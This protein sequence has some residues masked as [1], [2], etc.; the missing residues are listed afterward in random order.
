MKETLR[1]KMKETLRNKLEILLSQYQFEKGQAQD[2]MHESSLKGNWDEARQY[3]E[4]A[5]AY[6]WFISDLKEA[7]K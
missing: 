7:L 1:N 3:D 2:R 4:K 6:T 5:K